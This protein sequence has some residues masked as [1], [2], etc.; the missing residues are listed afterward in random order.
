MR[1]GVK[2]SV[3][4]YLHIHMLH[5]KRLILNTSCQILAFKIQNKGLNTLIGELEA[6][7]EKAHQMHMIPTVTVQNHRLQILPSLRGRQRNC[8]EFS[9]LL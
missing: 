3:Q 7:K 2:F 8:K 5:F 9:M 4:W 6:F 1:N